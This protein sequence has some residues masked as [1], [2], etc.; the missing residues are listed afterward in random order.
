MNAKTEFSNN[1]M[2][3]NV[4]RKYQKEYL[5]MNITFKIEVKD[6]I[7]FFTPSIEFCR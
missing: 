7:E 3:S 1:D 6:F 2:T 4:Q 5:T